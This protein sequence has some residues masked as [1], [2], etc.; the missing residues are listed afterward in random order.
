MQRAPWSPDRWCVAL[1]G[2]P[3]RSTPLAGAASMRKAVAP[4]Q[5]IVARDGD[6]PRIPVCGNGGNAATALTGMIAN[7][8]TFDDT[9]IVWSPASTLDIRLTPDGAP[10]DRGRFSCQAA[11]DAAGQRLADLVSDGGGVDREQAR[12]RWFNLGPLGLVGG[13]WRWYGWNPWQE[14]LAGVPHLIYP[15]IERPVERPGQADLAFKR[16]AV[17]V[18]TTAPALAWPNLDLASTRSRIRAASTARH[19]MP[20]PNWILKCPC[21]PIRPAAVVAVRNDLGMVPAACD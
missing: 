15:R 13:L 16:K 9:L 19:G 2:S 12:R 17:V 18:A 6:S 20:S 4:R 14:R 5:R 1:F 8:L 10:S 3:T 11:G 7:W 21:N